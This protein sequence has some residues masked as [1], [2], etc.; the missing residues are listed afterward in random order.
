L[1]ARFLGERV[2]PAHEFGARSAIMQGGYRHFAKLGADPNDELRM[3]LARPIGEA[4]F[5]YSN[6]NGQDDDVAS[7]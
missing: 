1:P 3:V 7:P 6:S 5:S 2:A 4:R